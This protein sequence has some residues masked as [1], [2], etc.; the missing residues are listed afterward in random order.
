MLAGLL[1]PIAMGAVMTT[2]QYEVGPLPDK[3]SAFPTPF[4]KGEPQ[5]QF[6]IRGTKGWAWTPE[7]YLA[8][9][10]YLAKFKMNFLMNCYLSMFSDIDHWQNNWWEPIPEAKKRAY[11]KVVRECQKRKIDFCFAIHPQLCSSRP[12]DFASEKD[13]QDLWQHYS[14]MQGLGVHWFSVTLDDIPV[15][16]AGINFSAEGHARLVNRLLKKLREKD[17]KAQMVFCPTWYWGDG[18]NPEHRPYLE[19]LAKA[20]DPD[21]YL[22]WT[23]N[24][25]YSLRTTRQAAESY[26]GIVKHRLILWDNYP[27]NDGNPALHLGPV[28]RRDADL[29]ECIE[30]YMGNPMRSESQLNRV[31]LATCAD[32]AFNPFAYDEQRSIRQAIVLLGKNAA[33][34]SLLKDLVELYPGSLYVGYAGSAYVCP[35][36]D[37]KEA[38]DAEAKKRI[39]G[40]LESVLARL[41]ELFPEAYGAEKKTIEGHVGLLRKG[42]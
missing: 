36:E 33:E 7:Q 32:Y 12:L 14:W 11:E 28:I 25:V 38:P 10:P 34:R 1:L 29:C 8:E 31:P 41:K 4:K 22:F 35:V 13:F 40:R 5:R 27:V 16:A 3:P 30:G 39:L 19:G 21:V 17:P 20:L 2:K 42:G 26:R 18:T 9:I 23:G 37:F 6:K 15:G 24:E